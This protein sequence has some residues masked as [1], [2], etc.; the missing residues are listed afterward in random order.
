VRTIIIKL[1]SVLLLTA[2]LVGIAF[3]GLS[4][5]S[6]EIPAITDLKNGIR[7]GTDVSDGW[8]YVLEAESEA[9]VP[10]ILEILR[11]RLDHMGHSDARISDCGSGIITVKTRD[12]VT[13]SIVTKQ[14][15]SIG[16]L[17]VVDYEG[18]V[19]LN[20]DYFMATDTGEING[21][22]FA[23]FH[24]TDEGR[25]LLQTQTKA[26]ASLP[27]G[28]NFVEV[29]I[30]GVVYNHS[31]IAASYAESGVDTSSVMVQGGL[32]EAS[33]L[34]LATLISSG[35]LPCHLTQ[36]DMRSLT[37]PEGA[38]ALTLCLY[39]VAGLLTLSVIVMLVLY[40][41]QALAALLSDVFF[42]ALTA[43][44][45]SV[46]HAQMDLFAFLGLAV[47]AAV[48]VWAQLLTM[49]R[50]RT[51][52]RLGKTVRTAV[53]NAAPRCLMPVTDCCIAV[54]AAAAIALLLQTGALGSVAT[55][56]AIGAVAVWLSYVLAVRPLLTVLA[57]LTTRVPAVFG[58]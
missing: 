28:N 14:L 11:Y 24:L 12:M 13:P 31:E 41:A 19:L 52:Y 10:E 46:L 47:C 49:A 25:S 20:N 36:L 7:L 17:C 9:D 37:Q 33:A 18:N 54:F 16:H 21:E 32:T 55:V 38:R 53:Q 56:T 23:A 5:A 6:L 22:Y 26:I 4:I 45:L 3:S 30:D 43:V 50:I 42:A 1:G 15:T 51:E 34:N 58:A 48:L 40:R 8:M 35:K 57:V 39:A 44:C 27:D 2:I 29:V